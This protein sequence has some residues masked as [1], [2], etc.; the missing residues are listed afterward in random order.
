MPT[1]LF[2]AKHSSLILVFIY[3]KYP[4]FCFTARIYAS[5]CLM[6][7]VYGQ[8]MPLSFKV[9]M[10]FYHILVSVPGAPGIR[11]VCLNKSAS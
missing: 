5:L 3:Q 2:L 11:D 6:T 9:Y 7:N 4:C 10:S 1:Y 8:K